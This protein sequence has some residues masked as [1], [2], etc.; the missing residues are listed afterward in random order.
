MAAGIKYALA[1]FCASLALCTSAVQAADVTYERLLNPEPQNWL[2][3]HHDFGAHR[4]SVL[5]IINKSNVKN[6]KLAFAVAIGG[7]SGNENLEAT[8]LVEDGFMY[9]TDA[10]G[11][12]YKID[13]RS[14]TS[15]RVIWKMDPGQEKID[16]NRGVALW[17]NLVISVVGGDARVIATDKETGKIVWDKKL[18]DQRDMTLNAAPLA[19][20][21]AIIVGASGGDQGVR[22]WLAAL[23]PMTGELKVANLSRSPNPASPAAKPGKTITAPGR[24]AAAPSTSPVPTI[25]RTISP[26][27]ARAIRR[28]NTIYRTAPATIFTPTA[29]SPSTRRPARSSGITNTRRTIRWTTMRPARTSSSMPRSTATTRKILAHAGRNGFYY[30]FDRGSGQFLKSTQYV[31]TVTWTKGV[32]PE[33]GKPADYDPA[34][35]LQTYAQPVG[36]IVAGERSSGVCPAVPGGS[37]FWP[38][39]YSEKTKL[40]YIPEVEGCSW[41]G[42][43]QTRHVPGKFEGGDFGYDGRLD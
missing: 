20:K 9:M 29:P 17:G 33:T 41:I 16:R 34:K 1:T 25:R 4:Y 38:A 40:L 43:D 19:L 32:D 10:W 5:D 23:D 30:N 3:N 36:K 21:D 35:D 28:R 13:V 26:I 2:T 8:P 7:T 42:R 24:P 18:D 39:A 12:V 31:P 15:G 27:G 6:L 37:N 11:V 14:G 22:D